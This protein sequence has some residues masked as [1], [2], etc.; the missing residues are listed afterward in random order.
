[1]SA[2]VNKVVFCGGMRFE[3]EGPSGRVTVMDAPPPGQTP[4]GS[5]PMELLIQAL[6]GCSGMDVVFILRKMGLEV[7]RLE[8]TLTAQRRETHPKLYD[9]VEISYRAK[10]V[11]LGMGELE[12]AVR[13]S[14][15][16]YCSVALSISPPTH[17][18]WNC[19]LLA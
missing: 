2:S 10:G 14:L 16:K 8:I 19:G 17:I 15:E 7:D 12:K 11:G 1:M 9:S 6:G 3:G 13:M 18:E 4:A 5:A